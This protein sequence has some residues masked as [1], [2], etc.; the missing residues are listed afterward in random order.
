[1]VLQEELRPYLINLYK[2][3]LHFCN[4]IYRS[5]DD[6]FYYLIFIPVGLALLPV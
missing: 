1:M 6:E 5:G 4:E 2:K 3:N